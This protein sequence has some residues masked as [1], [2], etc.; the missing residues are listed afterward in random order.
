[1]GMTSNRPYLLRALNEWI[2]DNGMAPYIL[3]DAKFPGTSVP[4]EF[5]Q[6]GKIVLNISSSAVKDLMINNDLLTCTAR[7]AGKST[8]LQCPIA[9]VTA[10]YASENGHGM[11]F[12]EE[13]ETEEE[14]KK[15]SVPVHKKPDLKL[16][17]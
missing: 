12:P 15:I 16:I 5:I 14:T 3:V 11:I 4:G 10:I 8:S 2:I 6:D 1:M 9:A 17:K 13:E 7:F